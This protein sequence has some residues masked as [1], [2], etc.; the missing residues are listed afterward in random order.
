MVNKVVGIGWPSIDQMIGV[1][2]VKGVGRRN[3][4]GKGCYHRRLP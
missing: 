2:E 1:I 3:F 4:T